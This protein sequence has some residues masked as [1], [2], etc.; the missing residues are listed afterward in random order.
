[1]CEC[2][3]ISNL[4]CQK[5]IGAIFRVIAFCFLICFFFCRRSLEDQQ[6]VKQI[7]MSEALSRDDIQVAFICTENTNHEEHIRWSTHIFSLLMIISCNPTHVTDPTSFLFILR[8]F[9]EAGRHVCVEYPM[10]LS[11]G[12][13]VDLWDLAQEK[14]ELQ[15]WPSSLESSLKS[16]VHIWS[17]TNCNNQ[18]F[19]QPATLFTFLSYVQGWCYMRNILN[20]S[21]LISNSWKKT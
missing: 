7:S 12:S 20:F 5:T 8:Q 2:L 4:N 15:T 16:F 11:Y 6:G 14:G 9:L 10:T 17:V 3:S 13:A 1:M 18:R 19:C 21:L